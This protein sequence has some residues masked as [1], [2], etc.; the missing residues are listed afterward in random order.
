M[1]YVGN[2]DLKVFMC[3][4]EMFLKTFNVGPWWWS[5][6]SPST[7]MIL[8]KPTVFLYKISYE[9]NENKQKDAGLCPFNVHML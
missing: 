9:K 3:V 8:L 5:A 4:I 1:L 7:K 6:C 2:E